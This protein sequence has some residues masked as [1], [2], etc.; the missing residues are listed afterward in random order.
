M[1]R[2]KLRGWELD[3]LDELN[4]IV[5][6]IELSIDNDALRWKGNDDNFN[7]KDCYRII[8]SNGNAF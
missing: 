5:K 7:T 4:D 2:R 8:T 3:S 1:W 6:S